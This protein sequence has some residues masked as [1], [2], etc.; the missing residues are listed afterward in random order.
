MSGS[1]T[2]REG[3]LV[4]EGVLTAIVLTNVLLGLYAVWYWCAR[5][6]ERRHP[7]GREWWEKR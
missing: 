5:R 7:P 4:F 6:L 2:L 3:P 1:G